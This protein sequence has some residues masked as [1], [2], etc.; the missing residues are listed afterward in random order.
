MRNDTDKEVQ[1]VKGT[2]EGISDDL[3]EKINANIVDTRKGTER[4]AYEVNARSKSLIEEMQKYKGD[5]ENKI[6]S[7]RQDFSKFREEVTADH[8]RWQL[9]AGTRY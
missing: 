4:V 7:V 3:H 8:A 9:K 2:I 5:T 6:M 1:Q